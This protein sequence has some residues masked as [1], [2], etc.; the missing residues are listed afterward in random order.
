MA[1]SRKTYAIGEL[2]LWHPGATLNSLQEL[3]Q[4]QLTL[5]IANPKTAPYGQAAQAILNTLD[6]ARSWPLITG[7]SIAQ[8]YQF[9]ASGN[10]PAGFISRS[11]VTA[12]MT[13]LKSIP[14]DWYQPLVQQM[15]LTRKAENTPQAMAFFHYLESPEAHNIIRKHGYRLPTDK[16]SSTTGLAL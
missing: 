12:D 10:V 16:P 8:T 9:V 1:G 13:D 11:Q 14:T 4:R 3:T 7:T 6:P 15:V 2:V 5:A